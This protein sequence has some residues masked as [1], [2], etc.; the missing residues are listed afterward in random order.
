MSGVKLIKIKE[1]ILADNRGLADK[2]RKR[3]A[4]SGTLMLN[5]MAS[6]GGGKTSLILQTIARLGDAIRIGVI[7]A[8]LD[9]TV[10]SDKIATVGVP[11]VQ[12]ETGGFCHVD[13]A[14]VD[15]ALESLDLE[16][17]DLV[18]V[19]NVGNLVCPAQSDTGAHANVVILSV[20]EGDDKP[21]KYPTM[22][23]VA[24]AVVVNKIDYT[25]IADFDRAAFRERVAPLN[26][27]APVFELSCTTGA[28]VDPWIAWV[29]GRLHTI[30]KRA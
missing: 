27:D 1:E 6:P 29:Q 16:R 22:F 25:E 21:L 17:I 19:E 28:G 12:I 26:P 10:D 4:D 8:D 24:H 2:T 18:I 14:M 9:S 11:A 20:P 7:E 30:G 3:L 23:T 13:A 5:L 15:R